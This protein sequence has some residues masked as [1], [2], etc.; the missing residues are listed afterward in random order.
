MLTGFR[1][2]VPS[3]LHHLEF[4]FISLTL[5]LCHDLWLNLETLLPVRI[6]KWFI[7]W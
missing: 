7:K 5:G 3:M 2:L 4:R 6:G 1:P